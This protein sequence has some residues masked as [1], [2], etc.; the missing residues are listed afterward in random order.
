MRLKLLSA[1]AARRARR[2]GRGLSSSKGKTC[3]RGHKGQRARSG[4]KKYNLEGGQTPL[5]RRLPKRGFKRARNELRALSLSVLNKRLQHT[6]SDLRTY[7]T[8]SLK[9][10]LGIKPKFKLK[11]LAG[12][13][14]VPNLN[15]CC[16]QASTNA[17]NIITQLGGSFTSV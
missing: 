7:N 13:L 9:T 8:S 2:V 10:L 6:F 3:G 17:K 5:Y 4:G 11:L 15:L 12:K 1:G 16:E 14:T